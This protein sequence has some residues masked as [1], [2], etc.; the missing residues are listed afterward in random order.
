MARAWTRIGSPE[1]YCDVPAAANIESVP[2]RPEPALPFLAVLMSTP[3]ATETDGDSEA[4]RV[5]GLGFVY[6]DVI[7]TLAHIA[8]VADLAVLSDD[9]TP[10]SVQP[11][12]ADGDLA[13]IEVPM[14]PR[15]AL[16]VRPLS[17]GEPVTVALVSDISPVVRLVSGHGVPA[18]PDESFTVTL[19][20]H[21]G[22]D[23]TASGS[24]V[25]AGDAVVGIVSP[26]ATSESVTAFGADAIQQELAAYEQ[27]R[28]Q[29]RPSAR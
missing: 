18:E 21:L 14:P 2:N 3:P 17:A 5:R 29:G 12:D 4:P 9:T 7:V 10:L 1:G 16:T 8:Q 28:P 19:D 22:E 27:S 25:V 23:S 20:D 6:G 24:P 13:V 15:P 11:T 26:L